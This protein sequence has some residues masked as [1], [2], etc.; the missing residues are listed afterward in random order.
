MRY[1][2]DDIADVN[3]RISWK[4]NLMTEWMNGCAQK[5]IRMGHK[6]ERTGSKSYD[7]KGQTSVKVCKLNQAACH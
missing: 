5:I 2:G 1:V 3:M 4:M 6:N 7:N